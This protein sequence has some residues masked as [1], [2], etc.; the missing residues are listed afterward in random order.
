MSEETTIWNGT[1]SP[2]V[3]LGTFIFCGL[4]GLLIV[5]LA[6]ATQQWWVGLGLLIPAGYAGFKWLVNR[7]RIYELTTQRL[8]I[9]AGI[10]N[11]KTDELELYRV[12]DITLLSPLQLRIFGL[13]NIIII[14]HDE[15]NPK[16]VMEGIPKVETLRESLRNSVEVCREKKRVRLAELE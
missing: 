11:R 2:L 12:K 1:S 9:T 13:G 8:R 3:Y 7:F 14:S 6:I 4:A 5:A 10:L 15:T 16:V